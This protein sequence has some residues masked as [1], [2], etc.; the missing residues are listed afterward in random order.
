MQTI[1]D[2]VSNSLLPEPMQGIEVTDGFVAGD[3]ATGQFGFDE[4]G[5]GEGGEDGY[6]EYEQPQEYYTEPAYGDRPDT[7][8][9][10]DES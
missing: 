6:G 8:P 1:I 3:D 10:L 7:P 5:Y 9:E 2:V 4:D